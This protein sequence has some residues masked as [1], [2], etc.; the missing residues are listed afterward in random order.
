MQLNN[1]NSRSLLWVLAQANI[2]HRYQIKIKHSNIKAV[3]S[4]TQRFGNK[5][6]NQ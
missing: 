3:K 1:S 6:E 4:R 2:N 5:V